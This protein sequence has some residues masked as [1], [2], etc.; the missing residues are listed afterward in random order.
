MPDAAGAA[1]EAVDE[2][3]GKI[4]TVT[5]G[6][7]GTGKTTTVGAVASCLAVLG[8]RT[9]CIDCD[10]GMRNLDITLGM[11]DYAVSDLSDVLKGER[12]LEEACSEHPSI[13]GLFFLSAPAEM[14][15][16]DEDREAM[17]KLFDAARGS[18]DY[19]LADSP[20][21]IGAGFRLAS[22]GADTAIIVTTPDAACVRNAQRAAELLRES[23]AGEIRL[24]INRV[25]ARRMRRSGMTAD[26]II[27]T[28][29]V[30]LLGVVRE[31]SAV[32]VCA[33]NETPLVL[34]TTGGAAGNYLNIARRITGEEVPLAVR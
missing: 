6:K 14:T 21:G 25:K 20:A 34:G 28:V 8:K 16:S 1:A 17:R 22:C 26:D 12:T 30:R 4:I 18:F 11:T 13:P 19:C 2:T 33:N 29:G 15:L 3:M 5:S 9:L 7:G 10:A 24:I 27:D 32:P 23:G 31:D